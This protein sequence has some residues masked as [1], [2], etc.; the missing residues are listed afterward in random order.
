VLETGR[1]LDPWRVLA[2]GAVPYWLESASRRAATAAEEWL[3]GSAVFDDVTVLPQPPGTDCDAHANRGRWPAMAAF[4]GRRSHVDP[5]AM[6]RYPLLP[7]PTSHA[8]RVLNARTPP[9]RS[10]PALMPMN[11]VLRALR[12]HG[13]ACGL[14]VV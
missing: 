6:A 3:A 2:A 13:R 4:A 5:Q 9:H 7:L 10:P 11:E 1:L 14:L 12:E 8:A